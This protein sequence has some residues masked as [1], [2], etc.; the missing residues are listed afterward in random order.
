MNINP[1]EIVRQMGA[2]QEKLTAI[3]AK[4]SAGGGMVEVTFNGK[5]EVTAVKIAPEAL[6]GGDADML[7]DL[8]Q[9]AFSNGIDKIREAIGGEMGAMAGNFMPNGMNFSDFSGMMGNS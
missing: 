3:S 4:G 2:L 6:E 1:L 5:F 7:Q 8:V 9:A